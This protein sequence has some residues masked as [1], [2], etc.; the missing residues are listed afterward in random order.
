[1]ACLQQAVV[2]QRRR[3]RSRLV[4]LILLL[5]GRCRRFRWLRLC[6]G[7]ALLRLLLLLLRHGLLLLL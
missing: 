6:A 4:C 2:W 5:V 7:L 3:G 1:M